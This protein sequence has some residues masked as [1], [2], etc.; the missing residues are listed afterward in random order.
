[1]YA[2]L[3]KAV[4]YVKKLDEMKAQIRGLLLQQFE[5]D[6]NGKCVTLETSFT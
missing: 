2:K 5:I 6:E 4:K 1:M 3:I